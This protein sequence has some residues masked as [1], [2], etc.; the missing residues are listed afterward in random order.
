MLLRLQSKERNR[1]SVARATL[2]RFKL[3]IWLWFRFPFPWPHLADPTKAA[4]SRIPGLI[5]RF[6]FKVSIKAGYW[7]SFAQPRTSKTAGVGG[8]W[9]GN[10]NGIGIGIGLGDWKIQRQMPGGR[11][12]VLPLA[13]G[14]LAI[15][16][17]HFP[18]PVCDA[19]RSNSM[20]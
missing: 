18:S 3:R 14:N 5:Q 15:D 13:K 19:M 1:L 9:Y 4:A 20:P 7:V 6:K 10:G 8:I 12:H 11:S 17:S 16:S 2:A